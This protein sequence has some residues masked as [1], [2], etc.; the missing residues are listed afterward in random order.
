LEVRDDNK[1]TKAINFIKKN[2]NPFNDT[3]I[4]V[5]NNIKHSDGP[6][7]STH[8]VYEIFKEE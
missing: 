1:K 2:E 4:A 3:I 5:N 8:M 6:T 7:S